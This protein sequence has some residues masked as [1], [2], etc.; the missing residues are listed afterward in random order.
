[1]ASRR[2]LPFG[3]SLIVILLLVACVPVQPIIPANPSNPIRTVA[4]L[5][6]VNNTNDVDGP[7]YVRTLFAAELGRHQY[8]VKPQAEVDQILKDQM[9]VTLGKQLDMATPRQLGETLGVDGVIFGS[10][11]D[12][13]HLMTGVYNVKK[14]RVRTKLVDCKTSR[15]VWRNGIGVKSVLGAGKA[16]VAITATSAVMDAKAAGDDLQPLLGDAIAAPWF[17][18]PPVIVGQDKGEDYGIAFAAALGERIVTRAMNAPLPVESRAAVNILL[19]GTWHDGNWQHQ[20]VRVGG[21][22]I[23]AGPGK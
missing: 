2:G 23:P 7:T 8:V 12:F 6:F 19:N 1:M 9:S 11:D 15:T 16:G 4:V 3:L 5:P 18:L 22:G 21:G 14:V 17:E 10:L 20:P 13:N